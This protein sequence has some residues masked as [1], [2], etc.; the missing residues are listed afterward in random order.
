MIREEHQDHVLLAAVGYNDTEKI[1]STERI[2]FK[3]KQENERS[4]NK[5]KKVN[6]QL[7]LYKVKKKKPES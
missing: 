4:R 6:Q 5:K 2:F 3:E 1:L 7:L